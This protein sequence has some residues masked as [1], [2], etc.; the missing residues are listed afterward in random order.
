MAQKLGAHL[1]CGTKAGRSLNLDAH[2]QVPRAVTK[3]KCRLNVCRLPDHLPVHLRYAD[4]LQ[5]C[6]PSL[7]LVGDITVNFMDIVLDRAH[8]QT[9][10]VL[11][12]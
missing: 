1:H 8:A 7:L 11:H 4:T 10:H 5:T 3:H 6:R 2:T 9:E 12:A